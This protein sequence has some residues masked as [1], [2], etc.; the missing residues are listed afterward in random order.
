MTTLPRQRLNDEACYFLSLGV[1]LDV[2]IF[3]TTG[4]RADYALLMI[5]SLILAFAFRQPTA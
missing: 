1:A 4:G 3:R 5:I 2:L